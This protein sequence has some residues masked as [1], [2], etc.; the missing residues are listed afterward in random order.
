MYFRN[1]FRHDMV[2]SKPDH[3]GLFGNIFTTSFYTQ[4]TDKRLI[5]KGI[6]ITNQEIK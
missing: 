4:K 2:Y 6:F 5:T 1:D 3:F